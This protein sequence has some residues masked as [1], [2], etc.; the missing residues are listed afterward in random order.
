[1]SFGAF[2]S[3]EVDLK[4]AKSEPYFPILALEEP[5]AHLHPN[6]QRTLYR[7]LKSF[8]GQKIISTHSPY[9]AGQAELSELRHFYKSEDKTEITEIHLDE[10]K[11]EDQHKI[12]FDIE[13]SKGEVLF[14]NLV[15]MCEGET[16]QILLPIFAKRYWGMSDFELGINFVKTGKNYQLLYLLRFLKIEWFIF[17]DYDKIEV[18]NDLHSVLLKNKVI[19]LENLTKNGISSL[20]NVVTLND[21]T[22]Q[23]DIEEY[24]FDSGYELELRNAL[25]QLKEP[26]YQNERHKLAKKAE[27]DKENERID[28]LGKAN[29]IKELDNWKTKAAP[30]YAHL[31]L[32]KAD[33]SE[34][35]PQKIKE[36]LDKISVQLGVPKQ[37]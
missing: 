27:V 4:A 1:M 2:S 7:Q 35:F 29:F 33:E 36:L 3:W 16:E 14:S 11:E 6:A 10:L 18:K 19:S 31:I 8:G 17:S 26:E 20:H 15:V 22:T 37:V 24:L 23:K 30:I 5:E 34:R 32:N 28:S 12:R 13:S 21:G 25:K 9:L